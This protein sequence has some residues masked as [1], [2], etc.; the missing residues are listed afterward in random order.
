MTKPF[1]FSALNFVKFSSDSMLDKFKFM[2][3]GTITDGINICIFKFFPASTK[4][5]FKD[6]V[7]RI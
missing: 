4:I 1:Q 2:C 3:N 7:I 5:L 6:Q